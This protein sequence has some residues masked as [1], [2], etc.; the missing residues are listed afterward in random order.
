MKRSYAR[1]QMMPGSI[2]FSPGLSIEVSSAQK[3]GSVQ[4]YSN[5]IIE[6]TKSVAAWILSNDEVSRFCD[7]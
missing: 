5:A 6:F 3:S 1:F 7:F 4:G 2:F